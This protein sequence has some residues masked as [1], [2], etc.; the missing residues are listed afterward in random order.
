MNAILKYV[1]N[2]NVR[3]NTPFIIKN[4]RGYYLVDGKLISQKRFED[5]YPLP[6]VPGRNAE[7]P[8]RTFSFLNES[9]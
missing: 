5:Q 6:L 2:R 7:N 1:D 3:I 9:I 4:G 8:D